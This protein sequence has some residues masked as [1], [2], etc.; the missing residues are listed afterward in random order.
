MKKMVLVLTLAVFA[1]C[2][3]SFAQD[4]NYF[5]NIGI[6]LDESADAFCAETLAPGNYPA[7]LVLT[8]VDPGFVTGFECKI[9]LEGSGFMVG[10]AARGN[11]IDAATKP[12]EHIVG[13]ADP[14]LP[15][16]DGKCVVADMTVIIADANPTALFIDG[17]FFSSLSGQVPAILSNGELIEAHPSLGTSSDPVLILNSPCEAVAVEDAAWGSVKSLY[18]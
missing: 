8:K 2:G 12:G 18:R 10:F 11:H 7:Y 5:N 16:V 17:V 6:Y 15:V 13:I 1:L 14:G 4:P 9:T 3:S